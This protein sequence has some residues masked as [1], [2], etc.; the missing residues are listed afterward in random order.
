[1]RTQIHQVQQN[2][3]K[4]IHILKPILFLLIAGTFYHRE[5]L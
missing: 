2:I 1:M 3:N 4:E 5:V